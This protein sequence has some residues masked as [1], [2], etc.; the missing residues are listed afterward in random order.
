MYGTCFL[1]KSSAASMSST[2]WTPPKTG[3][4]FMVATSVSF[5]DLRRPFAGHMVYT[6]KSISLESARETSSTGNGT[7]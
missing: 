4:S 1:E 5:A 6:P 3:D 7:A 2:L